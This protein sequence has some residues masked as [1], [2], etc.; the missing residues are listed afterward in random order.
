MRRLLPFALLACA[1]LAV[2]ETQTWQIDPNHTASQFSVRHLGISTVRGQFMKTSGTVGYDPA[3]LSKTQIDVTIDASSVAAASVRANS[4]L[5]AAG[6][7]KASSS[8]I[9]A[10][11]SAASA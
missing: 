11:A 3:D 2:A 7:A 10:Q 4:S 9:S 6:T 8:A 5:R 1:S